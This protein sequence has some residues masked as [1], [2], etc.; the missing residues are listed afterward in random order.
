M[1][2]TQKET[3]FSLKYRLARSLFF[4]VSG[5]FM[6]RV[7]GLA[8]LP[9]KG[10]FIAAA[11]HC[12]LM[13]GGIIGAYVTMHLKRHMHFLAKTSYKHN[14]LLRWITETTQS[15][16]ME[17]GQE[18]RAMLIA[19]EYLKEGKIVAI[20]PEGTRSIDGRMRKAHPGAG[21]LA[22]VSKAPLVPIGIVG[23]HKVFPK[24]KAF[25][26]PVRCEMN[27]GK[28]MKLDTYYPAYDEAVAQKDQEK[29]LKIE[30]EASRVIMQEIA[31]LS[32]QEYPY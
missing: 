27:I 11:N 13:D 9:K 5:P 16:W 14:P 23:T 1:D 28:P 6:R 26:H 19:L 24:G 22:L 30:E 32:N 3:C 20:F 15:I 12:S 21:A 7:R 4:L 25:L 17:P 2:V 10:A 8:D 29:M 31:R 18:S